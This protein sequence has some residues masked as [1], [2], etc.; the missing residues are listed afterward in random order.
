MKNYFIE[1]KEISKTFILNYEIENDQ[2]IVYLGSEEKYTIPYTKENEE[3][4]LKKMEQ[5][6]L[7]NKFYREELIKNIRIIQ[8]STFKFLSMATFFA[9]ATAYISIPFAALIFGLSYGSGII[10]L[11]A[12]QKKKILLNDFEKQLLFLNKEKDLNTTDEKDPNVLTNVSRKTKDIISS[13]PTEEPT[14]TINTIHKIKYKDLKEIIK[15]IETIE[16]LGYNSS[17]IE[18]EQKRYSKK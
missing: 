6:I 18:E 3:I 5:Q 1:D 13:I 9:I 10:L 14:F 2:I 12:A 11:M 16:K 15:N 17:N 4:I 7:S 8:N